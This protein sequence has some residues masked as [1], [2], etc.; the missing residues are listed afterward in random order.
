MS[1]ILLATDLSVVQAEAD[2]A[3]GKID[4]IS[5]Q[6]GAQNLILIEMNS[7]LEGKGL[8]WKKMIMD[9]VFTIV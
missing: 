5:H 3:A 7:N 4:L 2:C 9:G 1:S 8:G 6:N